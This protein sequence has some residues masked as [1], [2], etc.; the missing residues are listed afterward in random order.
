[1]KKMYSFGWFFAIIVLFLASGCQSEK[2]KSDEELTPPQKQQVSQLRD[3]TD[4]D[5]IVPWGANMEVASENQEEMLL[6]EEIINPYSLTVM[7]QAV[8]ALR[9]EYELGIKRIS[10]NA[11][12][13]RFLPRDTTEYNYLTQKTGFELFD[14]PLDRKIIRQGEYYRDPSLPADAPYTWLYTTVLKNQTES[15]EQLRL[16]FPDLQME[17]LDICYIPEELPDLEEL[18]EPEHPN[19]RS[20]NQEAE[21][22]AAA[23]A[24]T[25][26]PEYAALLELKALQIA[27]ALPTEYLNTPTASLFCFL[28]SYRPKGRL[29]ICDNKNGQSVPIKGVKVRVNL[30]VKWA[31]AYTDDQGY[32]TIPKK[33]LCNP[34]YTIVF[35]YYD[36]FSIYKGVNLFCVSRYLSGFHS[37][38]GHDL[39]FSSSHAYWR[40]ATIHTTAYVGNGSFLVHNLPPQCCQRLKI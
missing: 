33:F 26:S 16:I 23:T 17:V 5:N 19:I 28:K 18:P 21:I 22:I 20:G 25:D 34:F 6:G 32:Y 8:T 13:I 31:H 14:Y 37:R 3:L 9:Q 38:R 27:E 11:A 24:S 35:E 4:P 15:L 36:N 12:Y 1:M 2:L 7:N 39:Y 40:D 30:A 10:G 29:T